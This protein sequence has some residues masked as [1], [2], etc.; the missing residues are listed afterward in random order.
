MALID[1]DLVKAIN[2][3]RCFALVGSGA[4]CELGVASWENLAKKVIASLTE[5]DVVKDCNSH[6]I[7]KE[8]PEIFSKAEKI[9]GL[10]D[11]LKIV[12]S[13]LVA[14]K[15]H[16]YI[17]QYITSW[18]FS[19][20]LTTNFDDFLKKFLDG[21]KIPVIVRKNSSN[22]LKVLRAD[23]KEAIFKIH[24][25]V[26]VPND[27]VLTSEQYES[28]QNDPTRRYWRDK[29][30]SVLNMVDL[31]II[32]YSAA[33]PDFKDQLERAKEISFQDILFL[34]LLQI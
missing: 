11:T 22:D 17:Y 4:S 25:D 21:I 24:G 10:N 7:K 8:Y 16:G 34:C 33:D 3:G 9:L 13:S 30:M 26:T 1:R 27:I 15:L 6:L 20:Y 19:C 31:V 12:E 29:I 23:S 28:F 14:K 32:G 18:P 5:P 2:L